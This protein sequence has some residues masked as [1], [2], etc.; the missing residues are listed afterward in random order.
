MRVIKITERSNSKE[1]SILD[2]DDYEKI[3]RDIARSMLS[4]AKSVEVRT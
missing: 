1:W 4:A 2:E 3:D